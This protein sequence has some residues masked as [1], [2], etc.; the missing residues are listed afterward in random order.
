MSRGI[1]GAIWSLA[2]V[3][4]A[5]A[6]SFRRTTRKTCCLP[7]VVGVRSRIRLRLSLVGQ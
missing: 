2:L 6:H 1:G 5:A 4:L 7:A 3:G